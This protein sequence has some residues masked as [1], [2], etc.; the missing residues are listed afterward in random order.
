MKKEDLAKF[1]SFLLKQE[2]RVYAPVEKDGRFLARRIYDPKSVVINGQLTYYPW[3]KFFLPAQE[4]LF[5]IHKD[6][7]K[8]V[9]TGK[10]QVLF[11]LTALDLRA[12][13]LYSQVFADDPYFQERKRSTIVIGQSLAPAENREFAEFQGKWQ[14]DVLEHIEF[15]I[16][17]EKKDEK[18]KV[19]TGSEDGQRLLEAFGYSDYENVKYVG[20]ILENGLDEEMVE[21]KNK[22]EN[23]PNEKLWNDLGEKCINCGKCSL[24]CPTCY[25]F[26]VVD[27]AKVKSGEGRRI[28]E[29]STCFYSDFSRIAG[30]HKFLNNTAKR[31]FYWYEHKFVCD[32]ERYKVPGCV[33]CGRCIKVCPVG[34]NIMESITRIKSGK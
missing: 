19:F 33:R 6:V 24:V 23:S 11:G 21:I 4:T 25:C 31:I 34:I 9:R 29:W 26:D 18:C 28:R 30:D 22:L 10:E 17:L 3:R 12:L 20:P 1:V 14:K 32:P 2:R 7:L 5:N 13:D 8:K 27:K 16:F 15:D